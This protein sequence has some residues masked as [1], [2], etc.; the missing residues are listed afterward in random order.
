MDRRMKLLLEN[1]RKFT[2]EEEK[3]KKT[4]VRIEEE[5]VE[6]D[7]GVKVRKINMYDDAGEHPRFAPTLSYSPA[8]PRFDSKEE[9]P[10]PT[11]GWLK[12]YLK[13]LGW[14]LALESALPPSFEDKQ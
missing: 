8:D 10:K 4:I 1:F 3:P 2:V 7:D 5:F 13:F 9:S 14:E 6:L 12:K 11:T